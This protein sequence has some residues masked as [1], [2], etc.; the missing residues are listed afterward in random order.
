MINTY[1]LFVR[2]YVSKHLGVYI[3]TTE[4]IHNLDKLLT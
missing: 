2:M 3:L 1:Y 4:K